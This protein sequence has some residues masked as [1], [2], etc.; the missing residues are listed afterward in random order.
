MHE[1][2]DDK[3]LEEMVFNDM[4]TN[5]PILLHK[6]IQSWEKVHTKGTELAK[7]NGAAR[8]HYQQWVLERVKNVNLPFSIEIPPKSS[9]PE[10]VH[11]SLE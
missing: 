5:D 3:E 11:V 10:Q 4:R 1:T 6:I 7:K 2:P 9:L 8:V